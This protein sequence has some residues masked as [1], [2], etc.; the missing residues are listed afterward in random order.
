MSVRKVLRLGDPRL[1]QPSDA[2]AEA[3][4]GSPELEALIDDLRD[5]M[6][7]RGGAGLAAPRSA[8]PCGW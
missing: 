7:E 4:F 2:G 3:L 5:T 1:R 8:C 6:A